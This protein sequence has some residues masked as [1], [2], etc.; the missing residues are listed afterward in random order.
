MVV[1]YPLQG[2]R[3]LMNCEGI[4]YTQAK[5]AGFGPKPEEQ[6]GLNVNPIHVSNNIKITQLVNKATKFTFVFI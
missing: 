3:F 6:L 1:V 5:V 2:K 4:K